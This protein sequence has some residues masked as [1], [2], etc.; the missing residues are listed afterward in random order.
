MPHTSVQTP[1]DDVRHGVISRSIVLIVQRDEKIEMGCV[2]CLR[3]DSAVLHYVMLRF[4]SVMNSSLSLEFLV[5][6]IGMVLDAIRC[7][8]FLC[9]DAFCGWRVSASLEV[10]AFVFFSGMLRRRRRDDMEGVW[11]LLR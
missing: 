1:F 6:M 4:A 11:E 8:L 10:W 7:F 5:D 3:D 2:V 9:L